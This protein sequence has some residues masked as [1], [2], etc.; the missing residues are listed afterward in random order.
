MCAQR[1][2]G[3]CRVLLLTLARHMFCG[4]LLR[5]VLLVG[6]ALQANRPARQLAILAQSKDIS[7]RGSVRTEPTTS[8][9]LLLQAVGGGEGGRLF[10]DVFT[11]FEMLDSCYLLCVTYIV[12]Y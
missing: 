3:S 1:L 2:L 4:C 7:R 11:V 5:L 12:F 10:E 6:V 9:V 8:P